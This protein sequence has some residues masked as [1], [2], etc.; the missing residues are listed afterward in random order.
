MTDRASRSTT[1]TD[2]AESVQIHPPPREVLA[3]IHEAIETAIPDAEIDVS[4]AAGHFEIRVVS[5]VFDGT[6]FGSLT[7]SY[8]RWFSNRAPVPSTDE[9]RADVSTDGGSSWTNMETLSIGT[10]SWA[11]VVLDLSAIVAP[12]AQM[13]FRFVAEDLGDNTYVEAGVEVPAAVV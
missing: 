7:L 8:Y 2:R 6:G 3:K 4:G 12:T 1:R 13:Q 10:D 5:P 11:E 9:F